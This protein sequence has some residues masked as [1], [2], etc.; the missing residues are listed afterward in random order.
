MPL[1]YIIRGSLF[2]LR[3]EMTELQHHILQEINQPSLIE[4]AVKHPVLL[5]VGK[6]SPDQLFHRTLRFLLPFLR[7]IQK[8]LP[9]IR[10]QNILFALKIAVKGRS[11]HPGPTAQ[12]ADR[13]F[14]QRF[15]HPLLQSYCRNNRNTKK[16][17]L[18]REENT[19]TQMNRSSKTGQ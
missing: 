16:I 12:L 13:N 2:L 6:D 14:P 15:L 9:D 5:N 10:L 17:N 7:P 1:F 4:Q 19:M 18:S 8:Q 3:V 11:P